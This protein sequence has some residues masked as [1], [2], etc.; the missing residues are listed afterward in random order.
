[1]RTQISE[2]KTVLQRPRGGFRHPVPLF[3]LFLLSACACALIVGAD[4]LTGAAAAQTA[5]RKSVTNLSATEVMSLRRGVAKMM[6]RNNAPHG[7]ADYH[8]SWVYWANMHQYFG[9]DCAG[10][11]DPSGP[12][13]GMDGIQTFIASNADEQATWCKCQHTS[14]STNLQFLTWH[15]MFLWYFERVLQEAAGDTSLRLPY[16]DYETDGT[17]PA[18]YRDAT[19]VNEN[20]Q[21]VANPLRVEARD[22]NLN[23]GNSSLSSDVTTTDD[24]MRATTFDSFS[25]FLEQTPHGAVHC[26]IVTQSC[27]FGLM[28][29]VPVSANDPIFYTHHTNIDRLYECWLGVNQSARLPNDQN[30]LDTMF[31]FVDGDG[32]TPQRRVRDMLTTAQLQYAYGAGG[33]CPAPVEAVAQAAPSAAPVI[34]VAQQPLATAGPTRLGPTATT[35]PLAASP[36]PESPAPQLGATAGRTYLEIDGLQYDQAPGGLYNVYLQSPGGQ[37]ERVGVINFFNVAPTGS[38]AHAGHAPTQGKFRFDV[39]RAVKQLNLS[40]SAQ[41]S[42]VFEPTTGLTGSK[43]GPAPEA[44]AAAPRMNAQANVRFES[45]RLVS[46]P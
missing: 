21:T 39:T 28:G 27:P 37:R 15:R 29:S 8:R 31:T 13:S 7:S 3:A 14:D 16:W 38:K 43:Q 44:L 2:I 23:N 35:V 4:A 17:L 6:S 34:R 42:L 26:S 20:G 22:P 12:G 36:S 33:G 18:A 9:N 45:A 25:A 41:P 5:Q 40:P 19:Y 30:L 10:P 46:S 1:M 24:A 32:S 11:I